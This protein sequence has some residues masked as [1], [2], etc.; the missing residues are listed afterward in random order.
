MTKKK[1]LRFIFISWLTFFMNVLFAFIVSKNSLQCNWIL[2]S[3]L[4][5]HLSNHYSSGEKSLNTVRCKIIHY[6]GLYIHICARVCVFE[7]I[8][9]DLKCCFLMWNF[10]F[11]YF[12]N[13]FYHFFVLPVQIWQSAVT[14]S[15]NRDV[16][17]A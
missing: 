10:Q 17:K 6:N 8:N 13:I 1:L 16:L 11:R 9:F 12:S 2:Q 15:Q 14:Y 3:P 7:F 4:T 5:V